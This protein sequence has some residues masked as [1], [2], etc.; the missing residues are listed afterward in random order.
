[1]TTL[2]T[3]GV[4]IE[5]LVFPAPWMRTIGELGAFLAG[6]AAAVGVTPAPPPG[7]VPAATAR[8]PTPVGTLPASTT[9]ANGGP[10]AAQ[11]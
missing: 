3:A 1:M 9:S 6:E 2:I 7:A 11:P 8:P 4:A 5:H 10:V